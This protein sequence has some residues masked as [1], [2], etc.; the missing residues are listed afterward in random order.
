MQLAIAD[1]KNPWLRLGTHKT[2][3]I[4]KARAI[5]ID[6]G[7]RLKINMSYGNELI[8]WKMSVYLDKIGLVPQLIQKLIFSLCGVK[9]ARP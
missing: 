5:A 9:N 8:N 3:D 2:T 6:R 7:N 4:T 1:S